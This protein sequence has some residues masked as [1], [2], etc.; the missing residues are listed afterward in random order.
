MG[1]VSVLGQQAGWLC[2]GGGIPGA[3]E[4]AVS[5]DCRWRPT[6]AD[7]APAARERVTCRK[8][9][10]GTGSGKNPGNFPSLKQSWGQCLQPALCPCVSS[11]EHV[12]NSPTT[13]VTVLTFVVVPDPHFAEVSQAQH[14]REA[15]FIHLVPLKLVGLVGLLQRQGAAV[16]I[17]PK[18]DQGHVG[19]GAC[20]WKEREGKNAMSYPV[21]SRMGRQQRQDGRGCRGAHVPL[22]MAKTFQWIH[23]G[24]CR[25]DNQPFQSIPQIQL[26][27]LPVRLRCDCGDGS[28]HR[29]QEFLSLMEDCPSQCS[30][31]DVSVV[32]PVIPG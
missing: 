2:P 21:P 13:H 20:P 6:R 31:G 22:G 28:A 24:S 16:P 18:Q 15:E 23:A 3:A 32:T 9:S 11:S 8:G 25:E 14:L 17:L 26:D 4:V 5:P 19:V 10:W 7:A 29:K 12:P 30:A 27:A 1:R